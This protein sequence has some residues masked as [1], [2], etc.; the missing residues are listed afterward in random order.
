[1][2]TSHA[3][4]R[5]P[6]VLVAEDDDEMRH[7]ITRA[8]RRDGYEV[9]AAHDGAGLFSALRASLAH[10]RKPDLVVSDVRMPHM[11]GLDL[12]RA[13]QNCACDVRVVLVSAFADHHTVDAARRLGV[14]YVLSK[15]FDLD[16]L[17]TV[18]MNLL[19]PPRVA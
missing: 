2:P 4:A 3:P 18:A 9:I 6:L 16:D 15:P 13:I 11:T 7:L 1:M 17:R 14:R 10:G 8:L 19:E 12:A 5:P